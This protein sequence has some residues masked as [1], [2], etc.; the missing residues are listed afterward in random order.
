[1]FRQDKTADGKR[2]SNAYWYLIDIVCFFFKASVAIY[3][4]SDA[5]CEYFIHIY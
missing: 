2:V 3:I 4:Y 5:I 1:M